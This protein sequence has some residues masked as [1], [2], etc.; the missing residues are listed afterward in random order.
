VTSDITQQV[1][2]KASLP[3]KP[4]ELTSW[5]EVITKGAL[6]LA[7]LAYC[8]GLIVVNLHLQ[9]YGY[10]SLSLFKVSYILAG[11]WCL[12][13]LGFGLTLILLARQKPAGKKHSVKELAILLL[14]TASFLMAFIGI[15][16]SFGFTQRWSHLWPM[17]MGAGTAF[18][19]QEQFNT[20]GISSRTVYRLIL[21]AMYITTFSTVVYPDIP[22]EFAGGRPQEIQ[23]L[24]AAPIRALICSAGIPLD[25]LGQSGPIG[26]LNE[27]DAAYLLLI[28][29]DSSS[30]AVSLRKELV[31]M[32]RYLPPARKQ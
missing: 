5:F 20:S 27:S 18:I 4:N 8:I 15:A 1:S 26:F 11:L 21:T 13:P 16:M 24:V 19:W 25:S 22:A 30:Q 12:L 10:S 7:G 31:S 14:L 17:L 32:V 28:P 23:I 9:K 6:T 3:W 2:Q 29:I